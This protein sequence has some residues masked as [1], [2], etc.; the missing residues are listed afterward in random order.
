MRVLVTGSTGYVGSR[1]VP[2]LLDAGHEVLAATRG[3]D[4]DEFGWGDRVTRTPLDL[5]DP[6]SVREATRGAD[7]VVYLVHSMD[8]GDFVRKDREAAERLAG[9]AEENGVGRMV[10]LSGL[11]PPGDLSDHL[12]SRLEVEEVLLGSSVP[13]VSLR[14]AMVI[15]SG[16]TSFELM[17]RMTER[18]PF[19]PVP[20]W[21]RSA[22]QP[23]AVE[24]VV[25]II[26]AALEG[27][28]RDRAYDVGAPERPTY[29]ELLALFAD[30]AGLRRLQVTVPF[31]PVG[32]VGRAVAAISGLPRGTVTAL[33]ESLSHD[34]VC[35]EDDVLD[36]LLGGDHEFVTLRAAVERSLAPAADA[37]DP[38]GDLQ[39]GDDNDP[40]WSGGAVTVEHGR[41][42]LRPRTLLANVL[43]GA[44]QTRAERGRRG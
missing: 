13:T 7:A 29:P 8:G 10:Y 28:P 32:L 11:I 38:H 41:P 25:T 31:L 30:V 44:A 6:C 18:V 21:M 4:L 42:R 35:R 40:A 12:R 33:V 26:A 22:V 24:D 39:S 1:L 9:A 43:L 3:S 5:E 36:D 14:A 15:G 37:T 23:I 2:V 20:T 16:S 27:E 19:T 34:M 17:R